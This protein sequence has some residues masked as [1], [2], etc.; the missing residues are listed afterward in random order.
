MEELP[1]TTPTTVITVPRSLDD[2]T[3]EQVFDQ[4]ALHSPEEKVTV[5]ASRCTFATP[6]GLTALLAVAET[7]TEK[8]TFL[9]PES[10]DSLNYWARAGFF[11]YAEEL[12]DVQGAVPNIQPAGE[13]DVLL[14]VTRVSA[15]ENAHAEVQHIEERALQIF[16]RRLNLEPRTTTGLATAVSASCQNIVEHAGCNGWVMIQAFQYERIQPPRSVVVIAVCDAG[17]GLRRSLESGRRRPVNIRWNDAA[18]LE[19]AVV[20]GVSRY[21]EPDRG[22][23]LKRFRGYVYGHDGKLS[24]RSGTARI[25]YAPRWDD[26][27]PLKENLAPFPGVQIQVTIPGGAAA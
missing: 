21:S 17:V 19:T 1:V 2:L 8:P 20:N 22:Q 9:P 23:Q 24:V 27:V 13:S 16:T 26:D 11:R 25:A 10:A 15:G 18:A 6:F 7:R 14:E 4:L 12:Y 3:F 5:D